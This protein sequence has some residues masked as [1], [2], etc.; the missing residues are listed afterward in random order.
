MPDVVL[1]I[2]GAGMAGAAAALTALHAG[3]TP[4]LIG[5]RPQAEERP[6]DSLSVAASGS[7]ER[8]GLGDLLTC[9]PHRHNIITHSAWGAPVLA[10]RHAMMHPEGGGHVLDRAAFDLALDRRLD[11]RGIRRTPAQVQSAT[12]TSDGR[13]R[14]VL[15]DS[16]CVTA[17]FLLD[18]TG[19]QA[20][21]ARHLS[22]GFRADRLVAAC[23]FLTRSDAAVEPTPATLIE[24]AP[25][26]W[27]YAALLPDER[28][29]LCYFSDPDLLPRGLARDR[30]TWRAMAAGT[31]YVSRWLESATFEIAAPPRLASAGTTWL[32]SA[33]GPGWAAAGDAACAFDPL[34]SHGMASALWTGERAATAAIAAHRGDDDALRAYGETIAAAVTDFLA[35]RSRIYGAERRWGHLPFWRRRS[36]RIDP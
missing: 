4:Q 5:P 33:C 35:Q 20:R 32:A 24:A 26:G 14:L 7:I 8:L 36:G 6:G 15:S 11:A 1:A 27:W 9:G 13:W 21:I 30:K 22:A 3:L 29:S 17:D 25:D 34:S 19:R 10:Q 28:L 12:R 23:S 18:C 16:A 31:T 2:A